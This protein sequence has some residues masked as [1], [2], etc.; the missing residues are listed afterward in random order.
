[1]S[2]RS[3]LPLCILSACA[4]C[5]ITL[6]AKPSQAQ[7]AVNWVRVPGGLAREDCIHAAPNGAEIDVANG[8]VIQNGSI[9]AHFDACPEPAITRGSSRV[10]PIGAPNSNGWVEVAS[11]HMDLP[12]G[13]NISEVV[14][15]W[16]VPAIP[17]NNE[18]QTIYIWNGISDDS[19]LALLQ[20]V[21]QFGPS[22]A[23]NCT[24]HGK[25]CW[26]IASWALWPDGTV[27]HTSLVGVSPGDLITGI[28]SETQDGGTLNWTVLASDANSGAW[29]KE[30]FWTTGYQWSWAWGA[31]LEADGVNTCA[32]FPS[33]SGGFTEFTDDYVFNNGGQTTGWAAGICANNSSCAPSCS[34]NCFD[35]QGPYCDF[36]IGLNSNDTLIIG[37]A[38]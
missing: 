30:T 7:S 4:T 19:E 13:D 26:G 17:S 11:D 8:N 3:V 29:A 9:V 32:D 31:V 23:G 6:T 28:T 37:L 27:W 15:N 21:L 12:S 38:Y 10:V 5:A 20:P 36:G 18:G 35:Y 16:T 22:E 25:G 2:I 24:K 34:S 33:G 1:M 14:G